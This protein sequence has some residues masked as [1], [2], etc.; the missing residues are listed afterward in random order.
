M[1][2]H[3]Y[4]V[5]SVSQAQRPKAHVGNRTRVDDSVEGDFPAHAAGDAGAALVEVSRRGVVDPGGWM[6]PQQAL[7][8][9]LATGAGRSD[10]QH[11]HRQLARALPAAL[12][13]ATAMY[14][15]AIRSRSN[16]ANVTRAIRVARTPALP[17]SDWSSNRR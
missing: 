5:E 6:R 15:K 16:G 9:A 3:V 12:L 14:W 7:V 1:S 17:I 13:R 2:V 10:E 8:G 11:P 4:Q